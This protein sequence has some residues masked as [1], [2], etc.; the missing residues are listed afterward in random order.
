MGKVNQLNQTFFY[1]K[2]FQDSK[3]PEMS[4]LTFFRIFILFCF[5]SAPI[6]LT[7]TKLISIL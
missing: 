6:C 5:D 4:A 2:I 3:E 1:L 7:F